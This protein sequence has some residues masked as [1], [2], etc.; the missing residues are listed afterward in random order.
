MNMNKKDKE[1][2]LTELKKYAG[3]SFYSEI[4]YS[5]SKNAPLSLTEVNA[6]TDYPEVM[7]TREECYGGEGQ[8]D[9]F[10]LVVKA[11]KGHESFLFR[12]D[13]WYASY[14]GGYLE[15]HP[16]EV[17]P[18]EIVVTRYVKPELKGK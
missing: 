15:G 5:Y 7:L 17:V 1:A 18:E 3:D 6:D 4:F 11:Q 9:E 14:D 10:W 8:G 12:V 2:I 13:G 16:Y